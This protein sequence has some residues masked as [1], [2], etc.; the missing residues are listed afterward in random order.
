LTER[1]Q[2][3]GQSSGHAVSTVMSWVW[4]RRSEEDL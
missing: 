3:S 2:E 4:V 1:L